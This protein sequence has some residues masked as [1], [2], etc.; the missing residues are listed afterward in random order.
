MLPFP[1]S[2]LSESYEED[3]DPSGDNE[4]QAEVL[5]EKSAS[6]ER[7][8]P[9]NSLGPVENKQFVPFI[10]PPS[11]SSA[12][13]PVRQG[14]APPPVVGIKSENNVDLQD[15][16]A[17]AQAAAD[18]ADRAA[19]A[20][21]S[22]ASLAQLRISELVKKNNDMVSDGTVENP[23]H[24][25]ESKLDD[26]EKPVLDNQ[27]SFGSDGVSASPSVHQA[28]NLGSNNAKG[29]V[30]ISSP[31]THLVSSGTA[32]QPHRLPSMDDETFLTYPNLFTR[33]SSNLSS[34][35][36]SFSENSRS[37]LDQ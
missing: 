15:V 30:D 1:A 34:R 13:V 11:P 23:F 17:A 32:H 35:A 28:S 5:L 4:S 27:S 8:S 18:S 36:Q 26:I 33:Q 12:S 22:A 9:D 16:L 3:S 19:A 37:T 6:K 21:R 20:A 10:S 2:A 24:G 31:N 29:E 7:E 14:N 25:N